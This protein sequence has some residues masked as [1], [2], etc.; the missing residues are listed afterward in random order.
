MCKI[1]LLFKILIILIMAD[2]KKSIIPILKNRKEFDSVI[3]KGVVCIMFFAEWCGHCVNTKP[4]YEK[5]SLMVKCNSSNDKCNDNIKCYF[6]DGENEELV[7]SIHSTEKYKVDGFPTIVK[8][9]DG[10]YKEMYTGERSD[11]L[12]GIFMLK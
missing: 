4:N 7:N 10:K 8:Y 2:F 9:I 3:K 11:K 12:L 6:I 1:D 5:A